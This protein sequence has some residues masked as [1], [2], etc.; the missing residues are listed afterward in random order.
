MNWVLT[1]LILGTIVLV[2]LALVL[3]LIA[4]ISNKSQSPRK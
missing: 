4:E 1:L 2:S 3:L